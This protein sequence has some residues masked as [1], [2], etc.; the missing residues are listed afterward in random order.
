M[1]VSARED[2]HGLLNKITTMM[3]LQANSSTWTSQEVSSEGLPSFHASDRSM[4]GLC[5]S[6]VSITGYVLIGLLLIGYSIASKHIL[7]VI[8]WLRRPWFDYL[9]RFSLFYWSHVTMAVSY[10]T[11]L[12][13]HPL[14]GLP[15]LSSP[16][17]SIAWVR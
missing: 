3:F 15:S 8:M 9:N 7:Y 4:S 5:T 17:G 12:L 6:Y 10:V 2:S 16:T 1:F 13:L 14:P 11:I